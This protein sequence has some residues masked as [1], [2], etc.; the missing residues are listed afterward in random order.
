MPMLA[1]HI[2]ILYLII[3]PLYDKSLKFFI[4]PDQVLN[5]R[6]LNHQLIILSS[7]RITF[8]LSHFTAQSSSLVD[9]KSLALVQEAKTRQSEDLN[10]VGFLIYTNYQKN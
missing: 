10:Y 6:P 4:A 8:Y 2:I 5:P 7:C 1:I 9:V 3:I